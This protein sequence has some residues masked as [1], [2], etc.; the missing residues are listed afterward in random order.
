[1]R[2][3]TAIVV[4]ASAGIGLAVCRHLVDAG[5]TVIGLA[6]GAAGLAHDR[7]R[8]VIAD[9]RAADYRD[10][11]AGIEGAPDLCIY[12][13]GIGHEL[14]LAAPVHEAEV[15]ATNLIGAVI[16]AEVLIPRMV[17]A[18]AG[19]LIVLSS[20]ADRLIDRHAPSYAASKAGMSSYFEGLA[21]AC[22]PH[23][24]A[25]TNLR[26]GFV[27]TAM[28]RGQP[29]RPFLITAERAARIVDRCIARRPIR[30]TS[31]LRM[32]ALLWL[33]RW[34]TRLRIWAS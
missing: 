27:D 3:R 33:V 10:A 18:R 22:R 13:A 21:L 29:V 30:K 2:Q 31:P 19:H 24:V 20:Q 8:H 17:A 5:W 14:D 4:G 25:I 23:G 12:A 11:I 28:S 6:R 7:Y 26:L 9:V 1:M 15:F 34:G 16:T 32:A